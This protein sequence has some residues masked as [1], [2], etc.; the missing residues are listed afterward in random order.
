M[1]AFRQ[2]QGAD[3][4]ALTVFEARA[5]ADLI[6]DVETFVQTVEAVILPPDTP[7]TA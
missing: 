2:R 6:A 5:A 1:Q 7:S 4:D 3:Y